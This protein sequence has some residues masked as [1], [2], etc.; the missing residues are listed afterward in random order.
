MVAHAD[1]HGLPV[2]REVAELGAWV[3][4]DGI[5]RRPLQQHLKLVR[6]MVETHAEH[7]LLSHDNGWFSVG[8]EN[9]GEVRDF[10]Y[11]A[12]VFLPA[13]QEGGIGDKVVRQLTVHNPARALAMT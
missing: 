10:N 2:N 3:S 4:Y 9:G 6:A 5:S 7:L 12:D 1:G 13:L 8:E 11:L